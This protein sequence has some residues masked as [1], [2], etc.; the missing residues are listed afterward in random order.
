M[1]LCYLKGGHDP[2][3]IWAN[4]ENLLQKNLGKGWDAKIKETDAYYIWLVFFFINEVLIV[5]CEQPILDSYS[6]Q[7]SQMT[8]NENKFLYYKS[9]QKLYWKGHV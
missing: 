4:N 3:F 7:P 1:F 5:R 8:Q 9:N 2:S 6:L